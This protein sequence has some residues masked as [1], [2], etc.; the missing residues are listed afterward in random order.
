MPLAIINHNRPADMPY[1]PDNASPGQKPNKTR[2]PTNTSSNRPIIKQKL[3]PRP[4]S[5][6]LNFIKIKDPKRVQGTQLHG[7]WTRRIEDIYDIVENLNNKKLKYSN[8]IKVSHHYYPDLDIYLRKLMEVKTIE[9]SYF[10]FSKEL[11]NIGTDE[12]LVYGENDILVFSTK[13]FDD[14]AVGLVGNCGYG[15]KEDLKSEPQTQSYV[16]MQPVYQNMDYPIMQD[17]LPTL[18]HEST[19]TGRK[20][21]RQLVQSNPSNRSTVN[22]DD[23]DAC[24][25]SLT[26]KMFK[27]ENAPEKIVSIPMS[28]YLELKAKAEKYDKIASIC[29]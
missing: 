28:E 17:P 8:N 20:R 5:S 4:F 15:K 16:N 9:E 10:V 23:F 26:K 18:V 1:Y 25:A 29:E 11:L 19:S 14:M 3:Y 7:L 27:H 13:E 22:D 24:F 2:R 6:L 21:S 12:L